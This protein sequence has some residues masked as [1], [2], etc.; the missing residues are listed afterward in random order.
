MALA[1]TSLEDKLVA[2]VRTRAKN[3]VVFYT[4]G[5]DHFM[6]L[7]IK[8]SHVTFTIHFGGESTSAAVLKGPTSI[9]D[10]EFHVITITR[11]FRTIS[12][13]I[14]EGTQRTQTVAPGAA[15]IFKIPDALFVGGVSSSMGLSVRKQADLPSLVGCIAEV[16]YN[17]QPLDRPNAAEDVKTQ[18]G[19]HGREGVCDG[20][21][22]HRP[23]VCYDVWNDYE[24]VCPAGFAGVNCEFNLDECL[25]EPCRNDGACTDGNNSFTCEC[26]PG[27]MGPTC[28]LVDRC[29]ADN[30]CANGAR[31]TN[32][33][34]SQPRERARWHWWG[35]QSMHADR[36][37]TSVIF[38]YPAP[39]ATDWGQPKWGSQKRNCV[40]FSVPSFY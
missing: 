32:L 11:Q 4:S 20:V 1:G 25:S 2:K 9:S 33:H 14:D 35:R 34:P 16:S 3:G 8:D 26:A 6:L 13:D 15:A 21:V 40:G 38:Q 12:L 18:L 23:R 19:C 36:S 24:C 39:R 37:P 17:S 22:C 7:E 31:K 5:A 28:E 10:G 27:W 30:P 29:I